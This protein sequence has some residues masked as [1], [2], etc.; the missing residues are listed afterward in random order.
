[1]LTA[2]AVADQ[3]GLSTRAVYDLA[4]SG[5]LACY[6]LGVGRRAVRFDQQDVD[7]YKA[8]CRSIATRSPA[9]G[10]STST[11]GSAAS[12]FYAEAGQ[13]KSPHAGK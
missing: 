11:A 9:V 10:C 6:R 8:S 4:E 12:A 2:Q 1:M 7:A 5:A 13:E 3:L